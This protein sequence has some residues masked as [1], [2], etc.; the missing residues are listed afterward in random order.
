MIKYVKSNKLEKLK[1]SLICP[2]SKT[3]VKYFEVFTINMIFVDFLILK[4]IQKFV[5]DSIKINLKNE[6]A[7]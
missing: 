4:T 7:S 2:K 6:V 3:L 1:K 5:L